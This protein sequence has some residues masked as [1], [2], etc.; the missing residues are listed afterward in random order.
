[1]GVGRALVKA[2]RL[3]AWTARHPRSR[4]AYVS[5]WRGNRNLGDELLLDGYQRL[6]PLWHF[7]QAYGYR[8]ERTVARVCRPFHAAMLAGGTLINRRTP[9]LR[10]VQNCFSMV[11]CSMVF[12]TGVA[13]PGFWKG[14]TDGNE[15]WQDMLQE[16]VTLLQR[17]AYVGVRGP[18]SAS[19]LRNAGLRNVRVVGDPVLALAK[20]TQAEDFKPRSLGL[21]LGFAGPGWIEK[22][23]MCNRYTALA[24]LARRAGWTVQWFVVFPKDLLITR[25]MAEQSGTTEF[26]HEDYSDAGQFLKT[27]QSLSVFVGMRMHATAL[28]TCAFVPSI[29]VEY[30]PK[31]RDYMKSIGQESLV[32]R[33][34]EF[35][36][37]EV[38]ARACEIAE[39]RELHSI[40]LRRKVLEMQEYQRSEA[41]GLAAQV[42]LPDGRFV[43]AP[44]Q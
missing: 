14:R 3:L 22:E 30:R 25:Y 29:M 31:C 41:Q 12:G 32:V 15:H 23:E 44:A 42:Q 5:G 43:C 28:A 35:V 38:W 37:S 24:K 36:A 34:D 7:Y 10:E 20:E 16:W 27:V 18:N 6:F 9:W 4:V 26:V 1:M 21:N 17:C 2:T 19:L 33:A 40:D 8:Y 39:N 13:D 11:E